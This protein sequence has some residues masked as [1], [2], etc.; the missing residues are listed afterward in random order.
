MLIAKVAAQQPKDEGAH[1]DNAYLY[2]DTDKPVVMMEPTDSSETQRFPGKVYLATKSF[3]GTRQA[4]EI[5]E[6]LIYNTLHK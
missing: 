1:V 5:W 6:S 3:Y 4:C 2:G